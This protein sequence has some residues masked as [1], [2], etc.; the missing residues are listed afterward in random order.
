MVA[1]ALVTLAAGCAASVAPPDGRP[2][3]VVTHAV[4]GAAVAEVAGDEARVEVIV[5]A[6]IDPHDYRPSARDVAALTHADLVVTNGFGLEAGLASV[7]DLAES[8]GVSVFEAAEHLSPE[9]VEGA[10]EH[11]AGT[12]DGAHHASDGHDH[13]DADPHFWVDPI[14][15]REVVMALTPVLERELGIDARERAS[16][17]VAELV[18]LD[19]WVRAET[20]AVPPDRRV[21]VTGHESMG[22]FA[23]RYG[24][25]VAGAVIPSRSTEAEPSAGQLAALE[26]TIR[27]HDVRVLFTEAGNSPAVAEAVAAEAGARVVDLPSVAL[28]EHDSYTA[29]LERLVDVVV[30]A[31]GGP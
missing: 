22:Y 10:V 14:A 17:L 13:G 9:T 26:R 20:S 8:D 21:L 2:T 18:R 11:A 27:A 28:A 16:E 29:Y 5:P 30:T 1:A 31:L 15:M 6:G 7:I 12:G 25:D 24:F 23:A 3:I 19:G 4:L